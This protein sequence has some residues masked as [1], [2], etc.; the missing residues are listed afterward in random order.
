MLH[1]TSGACCLYLITGG[2]GFIGSHVTDALVARGDNVTI[3]DDF[4]TG[5]RANIEHLSARAGVRVIDGCTTDATLV[6]EA[7]A[8]CRYCLH[9]AS[10]VGVELIVARALETMRRNVMGADVV[11]SAAARHGTRLL[12]ASSSEVYGKNSNGALHEA[13]DSVLG[14]PLTRRWSYAIAKSYGESLAHCYHRERGARNTIVR[15]FNTIGPRQSGAYG[16]VVPRLV[17]QALAGEDLTVYGDGTQSRCF[18]HVKD[19][20]AGILTVCD[21]EG[22]TGRAWNIGGSASITI[23]ALAQ[24]II[25]RTASRSAIVLVPYD[26]AYEDGFEELGQRTPDTTAVR[27]LTGWTSRRSLDEALDDVIAFQRAELAQKV[28]V[29]AYRA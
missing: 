18:L 20:A 4:S 1:S 12:F 6:D 29:A 5:R 26:D 27:D 13:A 9:L 3:L 15:L 16:M 19:A 21:H 2:G 7:M 22:A 14:S 25:A 17:R 8:E 24:R 11:I 28:P 23:R 10:A